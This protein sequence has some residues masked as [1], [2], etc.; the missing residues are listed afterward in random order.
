MNRLKGFAGSPGLAHGR[1]VWVKESE[2]NAKPQNICANEAEVEVLRYHLA[3]DKA[4]KELTSL[5]AG[6]VNDVGH[7]KAMI[8][9][10]QSLMAS[11]PDIMLEVEA[12]IRRDLIKAE[13]AVAKVFAGKEKKVEELG[14]EYLATRALDLKDVAA[15]ILKLLSGV[16]EEALNIVKPSILLAKDITP[17]QF[18]GLDRQLIKGLVLI[19]GAPTSHTLIL[20]RSM[21]LPAVIA[22]GPALLT[23]AS[24]SEVIIDGDEGFVIAEPNRDSIIDYELKL[25]HSN[26]EAYNYQHDKWL[27]TKTSD[28]ITIEVASNIGSYEDAKVALAAGAK[29][30]GLFRTE[31]LFLER[32]QMPTEEE[33]YEAYKMVVEEFNPER[34]VLRT[35]DVGGD[36]QLSY[37][38]LSKENNPFLGVRGIRSSFRYPELFKTQ[39]RA[40]C[41]ASAHGK[42][43]I[44]FPMI[45]VVEELKKACMVV[46]EVQA[47]LESEGLAYDR[48]MEIGVMIETPAAALN[49][50]QLAQMCSFFSLGTNDLLQYVMAADRLNQD[51]LYLYQPQNHALV[52][53]I[54]MTVKAANANNIG[55]SICGEIV[56]DL[57]LLPLLLGLGLKKFSVSAPHIRKVKNA[58]Q[59]ITL[60][61]SLVHAQKI[62]QDYD[63]F[64]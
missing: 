32:E 3:V 52:R 2:F 40:I 28:G 7:E 63:N 20:A 47:S 36:K 45:C 10:A 31:F 60:E 11:D 30:V 58:M 26:S 18:A 4:V 55:I 51:T 61:E 57:K 53:L 34:V 1:A 59:E 29:G 22:V 56:S 41:R 54:D 46:Q 44:M 12:L 49:A 62:L 50:K 35:L 64:N 17:S 16:K 24:N 19:N 37:L 33:Q 13:A 5:E 42:V 27:T 48:D 25:K 9:T 15:R 23:I 43:A 14:D 21:G 39:L 6:L 38:K 8:M